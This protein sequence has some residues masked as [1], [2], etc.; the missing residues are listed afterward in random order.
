MIGPFSGLDDWDRESGNPAD[1]ALP[2][3]VGSFHL[4]F[5][6]AQVYCHGQISELTVCADC[7]EDLR[8]GTV[9]CERCGRFPSLLAVSL[10]NTADDTPFTEAR[11]RILPERAVATQAQVTEATHS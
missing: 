11:R 5:Y 9:R 3:A 8:L 7:L 2:C 10:A 6:L 1:D 4:G